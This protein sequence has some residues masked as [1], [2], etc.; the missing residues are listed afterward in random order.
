MNTSL[1]RSILRAVNEQSFLSK[2]VYIIYF[3][4]IIIYKNFRLLIFA[5][6]KKQLII[7]DKLSKTINIKYRIYFDSAVS[8]TIKYLTFL[9]LCCL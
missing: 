6:F 4:L 1:G 8:T 7:K 2:K 5:T 3:N 9:Q